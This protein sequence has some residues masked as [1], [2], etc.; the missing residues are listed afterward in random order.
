VFSLFQEIQQVCIKENIRHII[1]LGDFFHDRKVLNTKTQNVAHRIAEL[2]TDIARVHLIL[3]NHDVY[4]KDRLNPTTAELFR[5]HD[6]FRIVDS[7]L[8]I[9]DIVLCPW[10]LVPEGFEGWCFGHFELKGFKMNN[11]FVC[12][13][14]QEP[15][16]LRKGNNFQHIYSG[17]F[18]T[19][20]TQ[21]NITYLG[22]PY[23]QTFHDLGSPRGYYIWED[24]E[25]DFREFTSAPK[26]ILM[27]AE[28]INT[29]LVKGNIVRLVFRHDQG[30]VKNQKIIDE[31]M[32]F[33]PVKMQVDFSQI[34]I[35]GTEEMREDQVEASLLDH[36][37]IIEEYVSKTALPDFA[38]R[39]MLL[40]MIEKLREEI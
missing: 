2:F 28:N 20:S 35:E 7:I 3:G 16:D 19:P 40:K 32:S 22:S 11:T 8:Q 30:S 34:K 15:A 18:H 13:H 23:Q 10:G 4:Y 37:Q 25:L 31:I 5:K 38:S 26:F 17:H 24:G 6:S 14:G 12:E 36:T 29:Q 21:G 9:D 1:H 39:R 27:E 33:T